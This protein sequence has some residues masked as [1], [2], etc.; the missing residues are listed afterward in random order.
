MRNS[1]LRYSSSQ[2]GSES[3]ELRQPSLFD[4]VA[5]NTEIANKKTFAFIPPVQQAPV[6][7]HLV[8]MNHVMCYENVSVQQAQD[9]DI[10][11]FEDFRHW[12]PGFLAADIYEHEEG[13]PVVAELAFV[14]QGPPLPQGEEVAAGL[15][16]VGQAVV[17]PVLVP[18][19]D[20][21]APQLG[22]D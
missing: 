7:R 9:A 1:E 10:R 17:V 12:E 14:S 18:E 4:N 21:V 19:L 3:C 5:A 22:F 13:E 6:K 8:V 15:G 11:C 16:V 20:L 2:L